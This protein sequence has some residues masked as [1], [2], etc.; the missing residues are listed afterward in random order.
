LV[1]WIKDKRTKTKDLLFKYFSANFFAFS[2]VI[3]KKTEVS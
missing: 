2:A 3:N 1:N